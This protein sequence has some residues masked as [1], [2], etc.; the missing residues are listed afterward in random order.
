MDSMEGVSRGGAAKIV[1]PVV[2]GTLF[3]LMVFLVS[4]MLLTFGFSQLPAP[5][6]YGL[7]L[8]LFGLAF[9]F[10]GWATLRMERLSQPRFIDHLRRSAFLYVGLVVMSSIFVSAAYRGE[11]D[12]VYAFLLI[13]GVFAAYAILTDGMILVIARLR[14]GRRSA[15]W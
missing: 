9:G 1:S 2:Y 14:S 5:I 12:T 4:V 15:T 11:S 13:G 10:C 8:L 6:Y 3:L 7:P